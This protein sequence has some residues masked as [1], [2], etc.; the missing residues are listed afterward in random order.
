MAKKMIRLKSGKTVPK[1]VTIEEFV[2]KMKKELK[3]PFD[4]R[5]Y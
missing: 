1:F 2:S 3:K 4:K 5:R